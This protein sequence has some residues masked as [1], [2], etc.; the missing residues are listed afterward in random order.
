M[1][2]ILSTPS[3]RRCF[4]STFVPWYRSILYKSIPRKTRSRRPIHLSNNAHSHKKPL[5]GTGPVLT[6]SP[7]VMIE[8]IKHTRIS[9]HT[10]RYATIFNWVG[11]FLLQ[12][13]GTSKGLVCDFFATFFGGMT[14]SRPGILST[15]AN[16]NIRASRFPFSFAQWM[17]SSGSHL[18]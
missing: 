2:A 9:W 6:E 13:S 18:H 4:L 3:H 11:K 14:S 16:L 8:A 12:W 17:R 7:R 10:E 15:W 5:W 1:E